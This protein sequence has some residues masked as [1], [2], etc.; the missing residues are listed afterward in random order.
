MSNNNNNSGGESFHA[1]AAMAAFAQQASSFASQAGQGGGGGGGGPYHPHPHPYYAPHYHPPPPSLIGAP[2]SP[3]AAAAPPSPPSSQRVITSAV[4]FGVDIYC[5]LD[6]NNATAAAVKAVSD[7]LDRSA[8]SLRRSRQEPRNHKAELCVKIG[9]PPKVVASSSSAAA[10]AAFS[11]FEPMHVDV[12]RLEQMLQSMQIPIQRP[13]DIVV[14]GLAVPE[15]GLCTAVAWIS[16]QQPQQHG[17]GGGGETQSAAMAARANTTT[18]TAATTS[19]G[20][21]P[22]M[23]TQTRADQQQTQSSIPASNTTLQTLHELVLPPRPSSDAAGIPPP[24]PPLRAVHRSTSIEMLARVSAQIHENDSPILQRLMASENDD[25]EDDSSASFSFPRIPRKTKQTAATRT[26]TTAAAALTMPI[27]RIK[28]KDMPPPFTKLTAGEH[29]KKQ[30]IHP[31]RDYALEVPS[32]AELAR[33]ESAQA[34]ASKTNWGF[35]IRLHETLTQIEK[36]GHDN[37]IGW[38]AHGRSFKIH[39]QKDFLSVILPRYFV[40]TKKSSFLRQLNLYGFNRLCRVGPDH[41]SYYHELFLKDRKFLSRRMQ[42]QKVNGKGIR[43]AGNPEEEPRLCDMPPVQAFQLDSTAP[44][45]EEK[46]KEEKQQQASDAAVQ[47][48]TE[49]KPAKNAPA[50]VTTDILSVFSRGGP[51]A[52]ASFPFRLQRI[53]DKLEADGDTDIVSWLPHG[54][55]FLVQDSHLFVNQV[56]PRFF[57]QSKYSSFQRQLHMY[58]FERITGNVTD[59]G[60]YHH[61][62]FL[63]GQ[64]ALSLNMKRTRINGNGTRK[65]GK[66][67]LEPDFYQLPP[68]PSIPRGTQIAIPADGLV[69]QTRKGEEVDNDD[70]DGDD[71]D[72]GSMSASTRSETIMD[73]AV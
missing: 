54:R 1:A 40:M 29:N 64:P 18:T 21:S 37:I 16:V 27:P 36:D 69:Q 45:K 19:T 38:L 70:D 51:G 65:P 67:E 53:L 50:A 57:N 43:T 42:R 13:F 5:Q 8:G 60:A 12:E 34:T 2:T 41:G 22:T 25:D 24:P 28:K 32:N 35:P 48:S 3:A 56:M 44:E 20:S 31:Y 4:G 55:G 9:V 14:G 10:A 7:A 62:H 46:E 6:Q 52:S 63:R 72:C 61:P 30:Y 17:G 47:L 26:A 73:V 23:P 68:M 59:K 66:P 33:M 71:D 11:A 15:R 49:K 58:N 39:K